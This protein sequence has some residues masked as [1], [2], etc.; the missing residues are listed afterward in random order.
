MKLLLRL[1]NSDVRQEDVQDQCHCGT[2]MGK[3]E[4]KL[5]RVGVCVLE[6]GALFFGWDLADKTL[7]LSGT[8]HPLGT[9]V[10]Q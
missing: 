5:S 1:E 7:N 6:G 4:G 2:S 9:S 3:E 10:N 8:G